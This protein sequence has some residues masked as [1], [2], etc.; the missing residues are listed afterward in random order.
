MFVALAMHHVMRMRYIVL[1]NLHGSKIFFYVNSQKA[2]LSEHTV[3]W[4]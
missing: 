2:R 3:I 4:H 1:C